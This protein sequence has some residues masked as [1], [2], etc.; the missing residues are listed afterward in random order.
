L[1]SRQLVVQRESMR[2]SWF[3]TAG[4]FANDATGRGIDEYLL[5]STENDWTAP[6]DTTEAVLWAVLRDSR[7]GVSWNRYRVTV[8]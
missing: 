1:A 6:V 7:G 3:A 2:V 4:S 5:V 8:R